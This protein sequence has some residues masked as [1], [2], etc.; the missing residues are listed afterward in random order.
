MDDHI[1]RKS[2]SLFENKSL[3]LLLKRNLLS[4]GLEKEILGQCPNNIKQAKALF[5]LD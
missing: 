5:V 3:R 1:T 4:K 2:C